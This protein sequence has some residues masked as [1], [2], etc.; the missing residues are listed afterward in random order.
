MA[1]ARRLFGFSRWHHAALCFVLL[2]T[3]VAACS[4]LFD[5]NGDQCS[6]DDD[7]AAFGDHTTCQAGVCSKL[8]PSGCFPGTPTTSDQFAIQCSEA[9]CE[10]FDNC[11]RL[12]ICHSSDTLPSTIQPPPPADAA[13]VDGP[14]VDAPPPP[15]ACQDPGRPTVVVGGSTAVAPF[16]SVVA[17]LLAQNSPPYQIVYQPSGSCTGVDGLFSPDAAKRVVKDIPGKQAVLFHTD[18]NSEPCTFATP[19]T[20]DV[21]VSDVFAS[22]C[23]STYALS[24]AIAEYLGP[25]QPMAFV[26]PSASTEK[27]ISAEMGHVIFGR[28]NTDPTSMPYTDPRCTSCATRARAPSR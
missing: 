25:I 17:P 10:P 11:G 4:L 27:S 14:V 1:S 28:G 6:H 24:D 7:C 22:S 20:L 12:G 16:L 19:T 13:T 18:G 21:A 3:L 8:G 5:H 9:Q 15:I 23:T 26:V 2:A